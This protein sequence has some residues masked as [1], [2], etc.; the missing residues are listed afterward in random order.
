MT[1]IHTNLY[2][3]HDRESVSLFVSLILQQINL[4]SA[5][6]ATPGWTYK[7]INQDAY[8]GSTRQGLI[9]VVMCDIENVQIFE[10]E[11]P[12]MN[13]LLSVSE[14]GVYEVD[15][16]VIARKN[17]SDVRNYIIGTLTYTLPERI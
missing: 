9:N 3:L 14:D 10:G 1:N 11:T 7:A 8:A 6:D 4:M 2:S 15:I 5:E 17:S 12:R 13:A 16:S